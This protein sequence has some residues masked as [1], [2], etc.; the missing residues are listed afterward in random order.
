VVQPPS[1][2]RGL[3][4]VRLFARSPFLVGSLAI[5]GLLAL[6]L[7]FAKPAPEKGAPQPV[8]L[9]VRRPAPA[10]APEPVKAAE[11]APRGSAV[12][13]RPLASAA[14][15]HVDE[16]VRATQPSVGELPPPTGPTQEPQREP[17]R[18]PTDRVP[19]HPIDL[20][21]SAA[22]ERAVPGSTGVVISKA[23][24]GG[25][26]RRAGD[27]QPVPGTRDAAA[28]REEAAGRIHEWMGDMVGR[29]HARSGNV[30]P[31]WR[32]A[33]RRVTESFHP[34]LDL[35]KQDNVGKTFAKQM[36]NA[37]QAG[38]PKTGDVPRG[39]DPSQLGAPGVPD[40]AG[41]FRSAALEQQFAAQAA[42]GNAASW[43]K[44]EVEVIVDEN[45][46][47]VSAKITRASGRRKYDQAALEA[48]MSAIA[49]HGAL[50]EKGAVITRWA[51]E[52]TLQVA[53]PTTLGFG[54]DESG[55]LNK[56]ATGINKYING[57]Y[58]M[59]QRV[60]TH[61]ALLSVAPRR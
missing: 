20:F 18:N 25:T 27:G 54:F 43:L 33:E 40:N 55:S 32:E 44:T 1:P 42:N 53:P 6:A 17:E 2:K 45:G 41:A 35:V 61:V 22:L 28:D 21:N 37:W 49:H 23:N 39:V 4:L 29:E 38:P 60:Q 15:R 11:P 36:L 46:E 5:H 58:P 50:D 30:A 52:A 34:P 19:D 10:P 57:A 7:H 31:R 3:K 13:P 56:G 8:E 24:W 59:Q 47:I 51:V 9:I 16:R 26:T 48:V 14:V 12:A